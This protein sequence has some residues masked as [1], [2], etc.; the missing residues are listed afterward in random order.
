MGRFGIETGNRGRW[1]TVK[2]AA[3]WSLFWEKTVLLRRKTMEV[4]SGCGC[5]RVIA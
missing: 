1:K 5:A 2:L 3:A 4:G